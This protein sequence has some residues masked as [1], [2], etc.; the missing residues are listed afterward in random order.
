MNEEGMRES[1][2]H[3]ELMKCQKFNA[4]LS[5]TLA[6]LTEKVAFLRNGVPVG[7]TVATK[8]EPAANYGS[9]LLGWIMEVQA[10]QRDLLASMGNLVDSLEV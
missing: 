9:P 10:G 7:Q 1:I 4:E 6:A 5:E 8:S 2:P 3:A